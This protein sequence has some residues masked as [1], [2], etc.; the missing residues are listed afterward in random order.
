MLTGIWS[1]M[2]WG[3]VVGVIVAY[4]DMVYPSPC[5]GWY[6]GESNKLQFIS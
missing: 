4:V 5:G 6:H 1:V 3:V 2:G